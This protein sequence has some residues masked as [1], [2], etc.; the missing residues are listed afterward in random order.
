MDKDEFD[1][2]AESD[3][4]DEFEE[5]EEEESSSSSDEDEEENICRPGVL[6][7]ENICRPGVLAE[8][9]SSKKTLYS[10]FYKDDLYSVNVDFI[11]INK[12]NE[13]DKIKC[14]SIL[15]TSGNNC[16]SQEEILGLLKRNS[17]D[18]QKRYV[19]KSILKYNITL[20][21]ED[22]GFFLKSRDLF[23]DSFLSVLESI[24]EIHFQKTIHMFQGLNNLVFLFHEKTLPTDKTHKHN[25][26]HTH[27]H[28]RKLAAKNP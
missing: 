23:Q 2:D 19:M 5:D 17:V 25:H 14:D 22:V 26:C 6:A 11:Y 4:F 16:I 28:K 27:K 8:E 13:I 20:D 24:D 10:D 1:T 12:Q 3:E 15:L 21:P 7:E 9:E 18:N